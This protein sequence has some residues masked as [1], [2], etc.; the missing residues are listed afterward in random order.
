VSDVLRPNSD[1]SCLWLCDISDPFK[2]VHCKQAA[3]A[4]IQFV[5]FT[6][7][8]TC[9]SF[10]LVVAAERTIHLDGRVGINFMWGRELN[11]TRICRRLLPNF[12][13]G[14]S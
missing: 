6:G 8:S 3:S 5:I 12:E 14:R 9:P 2:C 10:A 1:F 11:R 13:A 4:A 7:L